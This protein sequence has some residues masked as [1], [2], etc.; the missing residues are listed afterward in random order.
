MYEDYRKHFH[1]TVDDAALAMGMPTSTF[2]LH[3]KKFG[4]EIEQWPYRPLKS[5][6]TMIQK[7]Y[8]GKNLGIT[9]EDIACQLPENLI[10]NICSIKEYHEF[11]YDVVDYFCYKFSNRG[12][13]A[14]LLNPLV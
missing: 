7:Q 1:K 12:R 9:V 5:I 2:K 8:P 3:K 6:L 11:K 10:R 4:V 13:I 14:F